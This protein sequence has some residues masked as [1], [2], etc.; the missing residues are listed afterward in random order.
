MIHPSPC[1]TDV[2]LLCERRQQSITVPH[3]ASR[4]N[5][6]TLAQ[7]DDGTNVDQKTILITDRTPVCC[8]S[9]C[10]CPCS[11]RP[12]EP[13]AAKL[14]KTLDGSKAPPVVSGAN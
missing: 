5:E 6:P 13:S 2:I 10:S 14:D 3:A 11:G 9:W 8:E 12:K 4:P 1:A 7:V